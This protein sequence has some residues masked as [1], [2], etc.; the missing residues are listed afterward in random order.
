MII[1]LNLNLFINDCVFIVKELTDNSE[2]YKE[3]HP[4][5]KLFDDE[6]WKEEWENIINAAK[7]TH[8]AHVGIEKYLGG[9]H[10][11]AMSN[12][13]KRPILVLDTIENLQADR[14][15]NI[16]GCGMYLPTRHSRSDLIAANNRC[17]SPIVIGWKSGA[18]DHFVAIV[19]QQIS[20]FSEEYNNESDMSDVWLSFV[21]ELFKK[22]DGRY[23]EAFATILIRNTPTARDTAFRTIAN[24]LNNLKKFI[25]D[26][27]LV[28]YCRLPLDNRNVK[29]D[30]IGVHGALD[31]LIALGF[32]QTFSV[33]ENGQ[34]QKHLSFPDDA[35]KAQSKMKE[36]NHEDVLSLISP[37]QP[38]GVFYEVPY[39]GRGEIKSLSAM[40]DLFGKTP[41]LGNTWQHAVHEFGVGKSA[42]PSDPGFVWSFGCGSDGGKLVRNIMKRGK[43][44]FDL[45]GKDRFGKWCNFLEEKLTFPETAAMIQCPRCLGTMKWPNI[46]EVHHLE[47]IDN[48]C[49]VDRLAC[50]GCMMFGVRTVLSIKQTF[51]MRILEMLKM[52][53]SSTAGLWKCSDS[54][55]GV[56]NFDFQ[57]HC[58]LCCSERI[59]NFHHDATDESEMCVVDLAFDLSVT[60]SKSSNSSTNEF[61]GNGETMAENVTDLPKINSTKKEQHKRKRDA[62]WTC[63]S[64]RRS[65]SSDVNRCMDCFAQKDS[66]PLWFY[67]L[68]PEEQ[69]R[70]VEQTSQRDG[71]DQDSVDGNVD[72]AGDFYQDESPLQLERSVSAVIYSTTK[73]DDA[74]ACDVENDSMPNV[75]RLSSVPITAKEKIIANKFL[76]TEAVEL[77][78][79]WYECISSIMSEINDSQSSQDYSLNLEHTT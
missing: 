34:T 37:F 8:G 35:A 41:V 28:R 73:A 33:D 3:V 27:S 43:E 4:V 50:P 56:A 52:A 26:N 51:Y 54:V 9:I 2:W 31:L 13:L 70:I 7:P 64:C 25:Q 32:E 53:Y 55:C 78:G 16:D 61:K 62:E 30:I 58:R 36:R 60:E 66:K 21:Y 29:H 24:L 72:T 76:S 63:F 11:L 69:A 6:A 59:S 47:L 23:F 39:A 10:V 18:H 14:G 68:D 57:K 15:G 40:T 48:H 38:S 42:K 12:L 65:N 17:L 20:P 22:R 71:I 79:L 77:G 1:V 19:S 74:E 67:D 46:N 49:D 75:I 45:L 5:G 44:N